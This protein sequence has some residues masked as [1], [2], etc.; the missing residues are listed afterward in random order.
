VLV[1]RRDRRPREIARSESS[2]AEAGSIASSSSLRAWTIV[3]APTP[4]RSASDGSPS[5]EIVE[6]IV[7]LPRLHVAAPAASADFSAGV[8]VIGKRL[9]IARVSLREIIVEPIARLATTTAA[10]APRATIAAIR[11]RGSG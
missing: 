11:R 9:V 4:L 1:T 6:S 10:P 2:R 3:H 8:A 5:C 7:R